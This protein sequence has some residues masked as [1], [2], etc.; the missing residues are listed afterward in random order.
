MKNTDRMATENEV[1]LMTAP[2]NPKMQERKQEDW[3]R[4]LQN[5]F[6]KDT[7]LCIWYNPLIKT[8]PD[9]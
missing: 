1:D 2:F 8:R 5:V 7:K 4:P 6:K 9:E 3:C